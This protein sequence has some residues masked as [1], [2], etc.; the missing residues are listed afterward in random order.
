M[1]A[2]KALIFEVNRSKLLQEGYDSYR[3]EREEA[4]PIV[5]LLGMVGLILL[6]WVVY[7]LVD[8]WIGW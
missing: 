7:S 6:G 5:Y 2:K 4:S 3:Q 1:D 8:K